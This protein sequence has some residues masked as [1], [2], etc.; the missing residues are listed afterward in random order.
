MTNKTIKCKICGTIRPAT[1]AQCPSCGGSR[2]PYPIRQ[3]VRYLRPL[4]F[5]LLV[6][7]ILAA[8]LL[9]APGLVKKWQASQPVHEVTF[10]TFGDHIGEY[11]ILVGELA[12]PASHVLCGHECEY[13]YLE[14]PDDYTKTINIF[15]DAVSEFELHGLNQMNSISKFFYTCEDLVVRTYDGTLAGCGDLVAIT[16]RS[17]YSLYEHDYGWCIYKISKIE[18]ITDTPTTFSDGTPAP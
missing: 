11:V 10:E 12:L 18:K 7:C 3:V 16:G 6:I 9:F 1:D 14:D 4:F 2:H 15:I 5:I 8:G 17:C 13:I